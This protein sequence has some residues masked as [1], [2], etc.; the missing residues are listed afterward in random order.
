MPSPV[1]WPLA[2]LTAFL[3]P[4]SIARA[5]DPDTPAAA[6][7]TPF[8]PFN[9]IKGE[10]KKSEGAKDGSIKPPFGLAWGEEQAH[11]ERL[12]AGVKATIA[13]REQTGTGEEWHVVGLLQTGLKETRFRFVDGALAAVTLVYERS[14]W[15]EA[16]VQK[17]FHEVGQRIEQRYGPPLKPNYG[18]AEGNP[19]ERYWRRDG[20]LRLQ[21]QS[22]G[23]GGGQIIVSYAR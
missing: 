14:G 8:P 1:A 10:G 9:E 20:I 12:M 23:D 11:V 17:F 22:Y 5:A 19:P 7:P 18:A 6:K 15:S 16:E 13:S 21:R 3:L 2:A 4:L